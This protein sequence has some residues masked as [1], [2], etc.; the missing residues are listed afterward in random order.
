MHKLF[1]SR[2]AAVLAVL[3][4]ATWSL[5]AQGIRGRGQPGAGGPGAGAGGPG[6]PGA[7]GGRERY[8]PPITDEKLL[9]LHREFIKKAEKLANDYGR[10]KDPDKARIVYEQILK[11]DPGHAGA[12]AAMAK[13]KEREETA[14]KKVMDIMANKSFQDTGVYTVPGKP[15]KIEAE[16]QWKMVISEQ[17]GPNGFEIPKELREFNLGSLVGYIDTG[18]KESSKP[19]LVGAEYEDVGPS[20]SG[21]IRLAIWDNDPTDNSGKMTVTIQGTFDT[22]SKSARGSSGGN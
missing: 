12:K 2:V 5:S 17:L 14:S 18:D 13:F 16:G 1:N 22:G 9:S 3:V 19:F 6:G 8:A 7:G 11:L 15:F 20:K 4:L 10:S 21:Q